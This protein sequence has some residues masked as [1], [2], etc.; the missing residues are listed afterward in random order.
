MSKQSW[1]HTL[2]TGLLVAGSLISTAVF[3]QNDYPARPI[4]IVVGYPPGGSVDAL[5]RIIADGLSP[6]LKVPIVIDN[7]AG[8]TGAIGAQKVANS[9]PDG[10]T[11]IIGSSNEMVATALL[12]PAQKYDPLKDFTPVAVIATAP[13]MLVTGERTGIKNL[14]NFIEVV[15]RNPGKFSYGS[16]GVGS[17]LHFSG[18]LLKEQAKLLITH[19]PY[20]GTAG[21]SIEFAMMSPTAVAPFLQNGRIVALGI[22]SRTRDP[23]YPNV[24]ALDEHPALKGFEMVGWF[25]LAGPKAMPAHIS[26]KLNQALQATLLDETTRKRVVDIGMSAATDK[27]SMPAMMAADTAKFRQL[28]KAAHINE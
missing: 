15:K 14:N 25:G 4:K 23:S 21:G 1:Y 6:R 10:Y 28:I 17:L 7:V 2:V 11:L 20:R 22:T 8:A 19:V 16:S 5:A 9:A 27:E 24:P 18:E 12:N 26:N 3:A 13:V